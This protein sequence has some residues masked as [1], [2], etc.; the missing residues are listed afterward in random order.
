VFTVTL[1]AGEVLG[2]I[3]QVPTKTQALPKNRN[4]SGPTK[5]PPVELP[6]Q[7]VPPEPKSKKAPPADEVVAPKAEKKL[8]APSVVEDPAKVL[9]A[10]KAR[11]KAKLK[12]EQEKKRKEQ[13]ARKK[14]KA[15]KERKAREAKRIK[16]QKIEAEKKRKQEQARKRREKEKKDKQRRDAQFRDLLR[17]SK[18][19]YQGEST[20]AGGT[21]FGAAAIGGRGTGG[22]SLQS[23]EFLAYRNLLKDYIKRGWHVLP[24]QERLAA[25]V[26]IRI[27]PSGVIQG[28][29]ITKSSGNSQFDDSVLRAVTKASPVP[30]APKSIYSSFSN[31]TIT[32]DSHK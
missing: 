23:A 20:D 16:A 21:G 6:T 13:Q 22:G 32:F 11:E 26:R 9:A 2:G 18:K 3:D 12:K 29:S 31:V 27:S 14:A 24:G 8:E 30:A 10:K 28:A 25:K 4:P 19:R 17:R 7:P 1:E 5:A 15:E